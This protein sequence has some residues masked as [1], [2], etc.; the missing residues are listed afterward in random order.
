[1]AIYLLPEDG[2]LKFITIIPINILDQPRI[3]EDAL[4]L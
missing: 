1:M 2:H 4:G 3:K